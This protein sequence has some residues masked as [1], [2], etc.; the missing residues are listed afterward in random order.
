MISLN[1]LTIEALAKS[2]QILGEPDFVN[3]AK[4]A[5]ERLWSLAYDQKAGALKHEIFQGEAQTDGFLQDYAALGVAFATLSEVT[6]DKSWKDRATRLA[7]N[8]RSVQPAGW[9]VLDYP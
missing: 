3:W 1:G 9:L 7:G 6:G 8:A 5:A 2:G 4:T